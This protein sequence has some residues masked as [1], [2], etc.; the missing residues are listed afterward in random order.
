MS[1]GPGGAGGGGAGPAGADNAIHLVR[2][3]VP[4]L[5]PIALLGAWALVR[6]PRWAALAAVAAFFGLGFWSYA[7]MAAADPR[8]G[9]MGGVPGGPDGMPGPPPGS[10]GSGGVPPAM[11]GSGDAPPAGVPTPPGLPT[12]PATQ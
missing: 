6:V 4:A 1:T 11:P 12:P 7:D 5:A 3:F 2:F 8:G 10:S 9:I